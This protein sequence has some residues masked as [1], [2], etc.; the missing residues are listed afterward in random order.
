MNLYSHLATLGPVG[1]VKKAPGTAG[2]LV[3]LA[4]A[5]ALLQCPYGMGMLLLATLL[6]TALGVIVS[7]VY[8]QKTGSTHD[9]KEIVIDEVAGMWLTITIWHF[10]IIAMTG[11][12][13]AAQETLAAVGANPIFLITGFLWFRFFDILKP[14]PISL[15]DRR[16]KGGIGVMLDDL[17][18]AL[19]AG[20][21]LY[22]VYLFWPLLTG[23]MA[24]S[25]V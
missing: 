5:Y 4:L 10:W 22:V 20:T 13:E 14:W 7:H 15:V 16:V 12:W 18:A 11:S 19:A 23:D 25:S 24:E 9:P 17:L 2:S 21:A 3:A 6:V 8:M 1:H